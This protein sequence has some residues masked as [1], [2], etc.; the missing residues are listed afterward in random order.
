M[1]RIIFI[2][3]WGILY[4]LNLP[5]QTPLNSRLLGL[6]QAF[7]VSKNDTQKA[8]LVHEKITL[9]IQEQITDER[10]LKEIKRIDFTKLPDSLLPAFYWNA[11]LVSYFNKENNYALSFISKYEGL[12]TDT[13]LQFYLLKT[14]I[15]SKYDT[16]IAIS[17]LTKIKKLDSSFICLNCLIAIDNFELKGKKFLIISSAVVPGLGSMLNGNV[18][19]GFTSLALSTST[20]ILTYYLLKNKCYVNAAG[21]GLSFGLKFYIGNIKL[22]EK[23]VNNREGRKKS[24]LTKNC[25]LAWTEVFNKYPLLLK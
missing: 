20:I 25:K 13:S 2:W 6:E 11:A 19:K 15:T 1:L 3:I 22:T 10:T 16:A 9:L 4:T 5:A 17:S 8:K 21:W 12:Q 14:L 24:E 23:L 18:F 7:Y